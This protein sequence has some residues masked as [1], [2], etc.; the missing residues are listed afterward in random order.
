MGRSV[1]GFIGRI[2]IDAKKLT[3]YLLIL[4]V[5]IV[6]AVISS[7]VVPAIAQGE[8]V[9]FAG[10][11]FIGAGIAV[12]GSTIGAGIA[13]SGTASSGLAAVVEKSEMATWLLLIAGLSEGIAIYGLIISIIILGQ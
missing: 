8:P 9:S 3:R 2:R 13:L 4:N 5:L 12:A 7:F 11:K 6:V 10:D 1:K